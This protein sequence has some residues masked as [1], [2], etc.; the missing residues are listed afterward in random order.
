MPI[1]TQQQLEQLYKAEIHFES[2]VHSSTI[3][4]APRWLTEE[5]TAIYEKATGKRLAHN[6]S[7]PSCVLNNYR[8]IGKLYYESKLFYEQQKQQ[9][10]NDAKDEDNNE[11]FN[12]GSETQDNHSGNRKANPKR[13]KQAKNKRKLSGSLGS[14]LQFVLP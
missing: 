11:L 7:C 1:F 10:E 4:S 5:V 13:K 12:G 6:F 8:T 3:R 9:N 2:A 14:L